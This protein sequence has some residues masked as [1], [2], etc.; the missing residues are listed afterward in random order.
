[1]RIRGMES[2]TRYAEAFTCRKL[3]L[4]RGVRFEPTPIDGVMGSR[5]RA[6]RGRARLLRARMVRARVRGARPRGELRTGERRPTVRG[7]E[8]SA[9]CTSS[10]SPF[11]RSSSSG[12]QRVPC[13][14]S[15]SICDRRRRRINRW[16]GVPLTASERNMLYV[17]EGCAHGYLSLEDASEIRYLT[18]SSTPPLRLSAPATT[19]RRSTS[20]GRPRSTVISEQDR[21]WPLAGEAA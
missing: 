2:A 7:P 13:G 4:L 3:R 8:R 10:A 18:T 9:A 12:A 1:M 6:D 14:T 19:I 5:H 20:R 17:P 21:G 15:P 11:P 16:F